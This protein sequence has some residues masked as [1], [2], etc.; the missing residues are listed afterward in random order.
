MILTVFFRPLLSCAAIYSQ[1]NYAHWC[2]TQFDALLQKA[3]SS[4]QLASRIEDYHQAQQILAT[5]L[6]VLPLASSLY[7]QAHRF[8]IKGLLLSPFG[9][10]S[11]AGVSRDVEE[12]NMIIFTL[13]HLLLL[14]VNLLFLSFVGFSL[15]YFT[16]HAPLQ[17]ALLWNAWVFWFQSLL[18][19]DFGVSS[20]NG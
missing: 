13:R 16:P 9:N 17:G 14:L 19:C 3:L 11:F 4:L 6:P 20:I 15:S 10:A 5:E 7:L 2:D 8:D 12:K 18:Q 1:T